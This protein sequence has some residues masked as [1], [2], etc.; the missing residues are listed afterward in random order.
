VIVPNAKLSQALVTNFHRPTTD[1]GLSIE[2]V[3]D[4]DAD[5]DT[6]ERI[7]L[8]VGAAVMREVAGGM[9]ES[10]PAVRFLGLSDLGVRVGVMV[11]TRLM[12]DQALIR[13]EVIKRMQAGLKA[14]GIRIPSL[15][16]EEI[17]RPKAGTP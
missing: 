16:G 6:V 12:G 14:A 11:R 17:R 2:F 3:V 4:A 5:L 9:P 7:G 8:E 15:A 10:P 13:H 1:S